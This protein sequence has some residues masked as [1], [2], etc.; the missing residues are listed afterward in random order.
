VFLKPREA[1]VMIPCGLVWYTANSATTEF[2]FVLARMISSP[3]T[4]ANGTVPAPIISTVG[5]PA[6]PGV[7]VTSS[8]YRAYRPSTSA[9]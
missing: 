5:A 1:R 8:P 2:P 4:I 9:A 6:P 3:L 7:I